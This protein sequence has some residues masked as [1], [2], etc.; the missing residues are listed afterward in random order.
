[1]KKKQD[2]T[3]EILNQKVGIVPLKTGQ[4]ESMHQLQAQTLAS[5]MNCTKSGNNAWTFFTYH[6]LQ[7]YTAAID[8]WQDIGVVIIME[9]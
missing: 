4:L 8:S 9:L 3:N 5:W 2:S 1:M 7:L 6:S